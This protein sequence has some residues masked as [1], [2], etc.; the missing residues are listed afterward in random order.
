MRL[1]I[2]TTMILVA[3]CSAC[4]LLRNTANPIFLS[5]MLQYLLTLQTYLKYTMTNFGEVERKMVSTQ[6]LYDLELIVQEKSEQPFVEDV[7]WPAKG[8]INF[9][10]VSLRYRP[11][12]ELCLRNLSFEVPAGL[13]VGVVGRTGA[14]KSTMSLALSRIV[15]ICGGKIVIDG[16]NISDIDINQVREK[17]TVIAQD[18]TLFTGTIRFNLD[19]FRQH[20][21]AA[22]EE[23]LLK[24]G[25]ADLLSREPEVTGDQDE[26]L[27]NQTEISSM[28]PTNE[29]N[30]SARGH[31]DTKKKGKGIYF[32]ISEAGSNL[33]AG[34]RQLVCIC[35]AILRKNKVVV[36]D[37]ATA[38]IDIVTEQKI[39]QL[40]EQE[41]SESTV[42][43]I[44]HRLNTIIKSDR[45]LLLDHGKVLEY[46]SPQTLME[47]PES[48]FSD[49]LKELKQK[50]ESGEAE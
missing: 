38:N 48:H 45:V 44:A 31:Q 35:R 34:E 33:S 46:D 23:L 42:I 2:L 29:L 13:K 24:A 50:K 6:R 4:I 22:I 40:I 19:P 16:V 7:M 36:L 32:K 12:T 26:E 25:L 15:E 21:N 18:P 17:I 9:S 11:N 49:L 43:T 8:A 5:M 3:G 37:E 39:Q 41:F 27:K 20:S 14:G 1:D 28:Q 47:N 10:N 30:T